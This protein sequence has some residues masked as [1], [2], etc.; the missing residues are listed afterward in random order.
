MY[1]CLQPQ[2]MS[3][4]MHVCKYCGMDYKSNIFYLFT[5]LSHLNFEYFENFVFSRNSII[6]HNWGKGTPDTKKGRIIG[7]EVFYERNA[8][9]FDRIF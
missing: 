7:S 8:K 4:S 9:Q 3:F 1:S 2:P 6:R 5:S